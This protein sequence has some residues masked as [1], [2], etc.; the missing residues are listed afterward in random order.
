MPGALHARQH[1]DQRQL[2][3]LQQARGA[4]VGRARRSARRRGRGPRRP[5]RRPAGPRRCRP[6]RGPARP[7][8]CSTPR[9]RRARGAGSR[10]RGRSGRTRAGPAGTG[11]RRARCRARRRRCGS[12]RPA[13]ACQASLDACTILGAAGSAS[14]AASAVSSA[15][16]IS[17][18]GRTTPPGRRG[19]PARCPTRHRWRA[20]PTR[21]RRHPAGVPP[22]RR[23]TP[24]SSPAPRTVWSIW[25][26]ATGRRA[27]ALLVGQHGE[28]AVPD[29]A[30]LQL[31]QDRVQRRAVPRPGRE[32]LGAQRQLEVREQRVELAVEAHLLEVVPQRLPRLARHLVRGVED[33]LR[34]RRTARSTW[35]PSSGRPRGCPAGCRWTPRR[36]LRGPGSGA[37]A[38]RT[39]PRRRPGVMR[40]SSETPL[41]GYSTVTSSL[42]SW[43]ASRSPVQMSTCMPCARAWTDRVARMS[44]AS[45]CG[46]LSDGM[47]MVSRTRSITATCPLNGAGVASRLP[48]YAS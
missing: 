1:V 24:A 41:T 34:A 10:W 42:T 47:C 31:L 17:A 5:G 27:L 7:A 3:V 22:G 37:A 25:A 28:Q 6:A 48:L 30:E 26:A 46:L 21:G 9:R 38:R 2:E 16:S 43:S 39:S 44:S 35:R 19:P 32:V 11:T 4:A 33:P 40:A 15:G 12:P 20:H 23:A 29:R 14:H 45:N 18:A 13:S 36:A 8:R